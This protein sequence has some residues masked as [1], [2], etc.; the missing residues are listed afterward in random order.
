M[1][2]Y[3]P[4]KSIKSITRNMGVSEFIISQ[5]LHENIRYFSFKMSNDKFLSQAM[6]KEKKGRTT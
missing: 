5:V 4:S 2:D 6:K 1:N 3:D